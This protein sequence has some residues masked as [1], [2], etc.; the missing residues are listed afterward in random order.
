MS[1]FGTGK[2]D[3]KAV[4]AKL[5]S[6]GFNG[7][8]MVEGVQVG[9]TAGDLRSL[10][11]DERNSPEAKVRSGSSERARASQTTANARANRESLVNLLSNGRGL[12]DPAR[13]PDCE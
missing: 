13:E 9:A 4:F 7:P 12:R 5:K 8:I 1:Q 11:G 6:V 10:G 3:F 2:V